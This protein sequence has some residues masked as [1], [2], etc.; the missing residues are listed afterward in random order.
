VPPQGTKKIEVRSAEDLA[1]L[2]QAVEQ[3][4]GADSDAAVQ[5]AAG[6]AGLVDDMRAVQQV[7]FTWGQDRLAGDLMRAA[8]QVQQTAAMIRRAGGI[9]T[10]NKGRWSTL[11]H[12]AKRLSQ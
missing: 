7:V 12:Q 3:E 2:L 5:L 8:E 11:A 1:A 4:V 10:E 9:L 6:L